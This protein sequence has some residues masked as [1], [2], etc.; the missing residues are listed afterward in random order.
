M[1]NSTILTAEDIIEIINLKGKEKGIDIT[2]IEI[3][4]GI[5]FS[6]RI[7][8]K[9]NSSFSGDIFIR[10]F[11]N[12]KIFLEMQNLSITSLGVLKGASNMILKSIV[13]GLGEDYINVKGNNL[14]IDLEK[15][16]DNSILYNTPITEVF[17]KNKSLYIIGANLNV[18]LNA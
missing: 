2:R 15:I 3:T 9:I 10:D 6:G 17:I 11:F 5:E 7:R 13:K 18:S 8:G 14:T 16:S 4:N 1:L 12:N